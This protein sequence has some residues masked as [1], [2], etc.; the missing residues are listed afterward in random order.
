MTQN[1]FGIQVFLS[2]LIISP[3]MGNALMF[4]G[5]VSVTG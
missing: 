1:N 3:E 2:D 4:P 5:L